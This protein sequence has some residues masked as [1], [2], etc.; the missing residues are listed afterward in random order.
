ML[1]VFQSD[2]VEDLVDGLVKVL[3]ATS[4]EHPVERAFFEHRLVVPNANLKEYLT[5]QIAARRGVASNMRVETMETFLES[6]LPLDEQGEPRAQIAQSVT[7]E[8]LLIELLSD[9]SL[10]Q[11]PE[12]K[13]VLEFFEAAGDGDDAEV[14]LERRRFQLSR[15]V[16]ALFREYGFSRRDMLKAWR[17]GALMVDADS[18]YAA[19]E[20]WQRRLWLELF[21]AG[22]KLEQ[23]RG[24]GP[25]L[26]ALTDVVS[27]FG[28]E[29]LALPPFVHLVG[30]SYLPPFFNDVFGPLWDDEARNA[31]FYVLSPCLEEWGTV[32]LADD[33]PLVELG[34]ESE[35]L[36]GDELPL[37]LTLWGGPGRD[38][39]R[40][41]LELSQ[42][43][44]KTIA[45]REERPDDT[46][47]QRLQRVIR[48]R[49]DAREV[50]ETSPPIDESQSLRFLACPS[51]QRECEIIASEIWELVTRRE[52]LR[53]NDIAVVV[54]PGQREL[55]QTHLRAAFEATHGIPHNVIDIDA[56]LSS[57]VLD[58]ARQLFELPLG[59]FKRNELLNVLVH[60]AVVAKHPG[61]DAR[62]WVR[63]CDELNIFHGA[64]RRDH[65]ATY[66]RHDRFNWQQGLDRLV[67]G[68]FMTQPDAASP[69]AL[70]LGDSRYLPLET[71]HGE[72][73]QV[74][75]LVALAQSLIVRSREVREERRPLAE[76]MAHF[77]ELVRDFI[78]ASGRGEERTLLRLHGE[79]SSIARAD[80]CPEVPVGYRTA[81]E[82]AMAALGSL[83]D[84]YGKYLA[85]GVVVSSF[86]P[87]RPIPFEVVF[88]TGLGQGSFPA[89]TPP[90][91]L[92]LREDKRRLSD[93]R[94]RDQDFYMFLE[95]L[96]S[97]RA[98]MVLSW[99]GRDAQ[100][101]DALEPASVVLA[102]REMAESLEGREQVAAR[103]VRHPLRRYD[104]RYFPELSGEGQDDAALEVLPNHHREALA[105]AVVR[106]NRQALDRELP[107][108]FRPTMVEL[109]EGARA[110]AGDAYEELV[111]LTRWSEPAQEAESGERRR[112]VLQLRELG[113]F[114]QCPLQAS[115]RTRLRIYDEDNDDLI[116]A[117][118][119]P[120]EPEF[121]QR[122]MVM[123]ATIHD[124]LVAGD[125][126]DAA[127][128][129]HL[130]RRAE[131]EEL[132]GAFP[133][134]LYF[135]AAITRCLN[136]L[137]EWAEGVKKVT[138]SEAPPVR[139]IRIG[140]PRTRQDVAVGA[141]AEVEV[142]DVLR[143]VVD[144]PNAE[145][146]ELEI[147][148]HGEVM[149]VGEGQV[150]M[151]FHS[152]G[153][154]KS[155]HF[156]HG[157]I[158]QVALAALG[159]GGAE[160][161]VAAIIKKAKVS[162]SK[163]LVIQ[164]QADALRYLSQLSTEL[165]G[166][167]HDYYLPV[168]LVEKLVEA[169]TKEQPIDLDT[170]CEA[171]DP[172]TSSRNRVST[173]YGPIKRWKDYKPPALEDIHAI[174]ERRY[175]MMWNALGGK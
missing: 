71:G 38:F 65:E 111:G 170:F 135:E 159:L 160:P 46:L 87:M 52:D 86:K 78:G 145:G 103:F 55:Y 47:L 129:K 96:M 63:W 23:A 102:M 99:V 67:L 166:D 90:D 157:A 110:K 60:P 143:L 100:T 142:H 91:S 53:F 174:L 34:D 134:D 88:V 5:F 41:L 54:Q 40:M 172:D 85:D 49:A 113:K 57:P 106:K 68:S 173:M 146:Q 13:P 109:A 175:K 70:A 77:K 119:E 156:T 127:L 12:M 8:R 128:K 131:L 121:L 139:R 83:E 37:A 125:L 107:T 24:E 117:E 164:G 132:R 31:A 144:D 149:V 39:H 130:R 2:R 25:E 4:P 152:S 48:D 162:A 44:L 45:E 140:A 50:R 28:Y 17:S 16:A 1:H 79:L 97:T 84:R 126:G 168:E 59:T 161:E 51:I 80:R 169:K 20:R 36:S 11:S 94:P 171:I 19:T 115:A 118:D 3:D 104:A 155:K 148:L 81:Y 6:L 163:A 147:E 62:Q 95:T 98:E 137:G 116:D 141:P 9:G 72:G 14:Q 32:V 64:D 58:A 154:V 27:R 69:E 35:L 42:G 22:G 33:D 167:V 56:S 76:W 7:I 136:E 120:F 138:G 133:S 105:E 66:I 61:A 74:A 150:V 123:R 21:K 15:R 93:V 73:D 114:L 92:D 108:G 18:T 124:A 165:I 158:E 30:F 82:F 43:D 89:P 10:L 101:G 122:L 112:V 26:V 29:A 75:A 153:E 151:D